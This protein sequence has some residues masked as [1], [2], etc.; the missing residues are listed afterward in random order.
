M[1]FVVEGAT[2]IERLRIKY[3]RNSIPIE[4]LKVQA[5]AKNK[6]KENNAVFDMYRVSSV[7]PKQSQ[8][9]RDPSYKNFEIV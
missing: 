1:T 6:V 3:T 5:S 7:I 2:R 4:K 9:N 8:K